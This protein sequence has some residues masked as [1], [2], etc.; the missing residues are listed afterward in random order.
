MRR[1]YCEGEEKEIEE[2]IESMIHNSLRGEELRHLRS[3]MRKLL[4]LSPSKRISSNDC[5][6]H[7]FFTGGKGTVTSTN[8]QHLKEM[9]EKMDEILEDVGEVKEGVENLQVGLM[10]SI[11]DL[12]KEVKSQER[13]TI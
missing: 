4:S 6:K 13:N 12:L 7:P 8:D 11:Q 5:V 10:N 9:N 2:R 1:W 3:L